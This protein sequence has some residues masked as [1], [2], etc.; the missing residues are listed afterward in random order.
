MSG[1]GVRLF[2]FSIEDLLEIDRLQ[3]LNCG[4]KIRLCHIV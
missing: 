4:A 2:N 3:Y 1:Q